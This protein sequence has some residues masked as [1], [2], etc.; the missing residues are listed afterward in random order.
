MCGNWPAATGCTFSVPSSMS[1]PCSS[2][3]AFHIL[4]T[5]SILCASLHTLSQK[6]CSYHICVR[7]YLSV[8]KSSSAIQFNTI[9]NTTKSDEY[10]TC[11]V[12]NH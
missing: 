1:M 3:I 10:V 6:D 11:L 4:I 9:L 12:P 5:M 2:D 8:D 7:Y